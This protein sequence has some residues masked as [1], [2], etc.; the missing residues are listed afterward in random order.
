M[1]AT[2]IVSAANKAN[3]WALGEVYRSYET[4]ALAI[5]AIVR[6]SDS[7]LLRVDGT[8]E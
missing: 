8:T 6:Q 7:A 3:C 1:D 4:I 2:T 5:V